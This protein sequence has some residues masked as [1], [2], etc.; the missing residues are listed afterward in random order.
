M[1]LASPLAICCMPIATVRSPEPHSWLSAQAVFSAGMPAAMAACRAGFWPV[2]AV[3]TCPK[4][5]SSTS[6][7]STLARS[8]A[9]MIAT[10]PS[11]CAGVLANAPLKLPTGVRAAETITTSFMAFSCRLPAP[12]SCSSGSDLDGAPRRRL[13][14][15]VGLAAELGRSRCRAGRAFLEPAVPIGP[16]APLDLLRLGKPIL[17]LDPKLWIDP[18]V[19]LAAGGRIDDPGN[20]TT[21]AEH[22]LDLAAQKV[23]GQVGRLPGNDVVLAGGQQVHRN[24]DGREVDRNAALLGSSRV[25]DGV[26]QIGVADVPAVHRSRQVDAVRIPIQ[27]VEGVGG[28]ALEII[29]DDVGPDQ[30]VGAQRRENERKLLARKDAALPDGRLTCADIVLVHHDADLPNIGEVEHGGQQRDAGEPVVAAGAHHG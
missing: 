2:L 9:A 1:M 11:S 15:P 18:V 22:E 4:I 8:I 20:M 3:S 21:G 10:L 6:P 27:E 23:R 13:D 26:L 16:P 7:G 24:L 19:A 25:L 12:H 29:I 17:R 14:W 5:T 28:C 30:V